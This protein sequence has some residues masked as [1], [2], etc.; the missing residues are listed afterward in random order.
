MYSNLKKRQ[1]THTI[2]IQNTKLNIYHQI[3]IYSRKITVSPN[4]EICIKEENNNHLFILITHQNSTTLPYI[5]VWSRINL[6]IGKIKLFVSNNPT[7]SIFVQTINLFCR[8]SIILEQ[9]Y[10]FRYIGACF[11]PISTCFK[12]TFIWCRI[13]HEYLCY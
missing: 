13:P 4:C 2:Q 5:Q 8:P 6:S 11:T 12:F 7:D 9:K 1:S 10:D 3:K